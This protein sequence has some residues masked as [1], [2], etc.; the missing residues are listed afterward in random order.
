[1]FLSI[2]RDSSLISAMYAE[3]FVEIAENLLKTDL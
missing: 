1:M 3:R 2:Y